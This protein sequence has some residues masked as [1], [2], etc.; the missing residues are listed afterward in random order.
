MATGSAIGG[1]S[2]QPLVQ[3]A[4]A[5]LMDTTP[6]DHLD[7][8]SDHEDK[9]EPQIKQRKVD[10]DF[11][12]NT[13]A[14]VKQILFNINKAICFRLDS[15]ESC[16]N[17]LTN[18]TRAIEDKVE[19]VYALCKQNSSGN[20]ASIKKG[21][22]VVGLPQQNGKGSGDGSDGDSSTPLNSI[23][24]I[25][26]LGPNV[27]LI[28]LNS[29]EDYPY[30]SWLGDEHNIETR[31]RS[32]VTPS[33]LL[34][35]HSNCRTPEKMALTLLDY[36]FDRETQAI[37]NLSG[38]GKHGKKQLDPLMIYG[39][40]CHL[41]AKFNISEDDWHRIKQNIDSKCRT[42]FRRRQRGMPLTV[43]AFRGKSFSYNNS[44]MGGEMMT[45]DEDS[46]NHDDSMHI[47]HNQDVYLQNDL[48]GQ[49]LH[50]EGLHGEVQILHATP[51]QISQL[52]HAQ[53]IQILQGDQVIQV[54]VPHNIQSLSAADLPEGLQ[55]A[56][57][58][59]SLPGMLADSISHR[60]SGSGDQP[61]S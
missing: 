31:V 10:V 7:S 2:G 40:R 61:D 49:V 26:G 46:M 5:G 20:H 16:L 35:I 15:I 47:Q 22:F 39:I 59:V 53:H 23:D 60:E 33:D 24:T 11:D 9:Y 14:S 21:A 1:S 6:E 43:K 25:A 8:S 30:G 52:Q 4:V 44:L 42:A 28:T 56:V 45:S 41:I 38:Q 58:A 32:P 51:E 48:D 12:I 37:S 34:H 57:S 13:D 18:R 36:L 17:T 54:P 29:E 3:I 27:T 19:Q 55:V 50:G